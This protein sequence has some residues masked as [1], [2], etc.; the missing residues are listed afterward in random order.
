MLNRADPTREETD[1]SSEQLFTAS[2]AARALGI[3][4]DT[5]RRWDRAGRI[6]TERDNGEPAARPRVR[7]DAGSRGAPD[8]RS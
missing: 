4:L 1:V 5:L 8:R 2:E 7:G 6:R 3:S